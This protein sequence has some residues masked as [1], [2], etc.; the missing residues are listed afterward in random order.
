MGMLFEVWVRVC[1]VPRNTSA[2][3]GWDEVGKAVLVEPLG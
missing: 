2:N 1:L 3:T